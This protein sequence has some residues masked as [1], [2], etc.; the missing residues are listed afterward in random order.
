MYR[1]I[2]PF[3]V[4][5]EPTHFDYI[6]SRQKLRRLED[7]SAFFTPDA[8][9]HVVAY[10]SSSSVSLR[11]IDHFLTHMNEKDLAWDNVQTVHDVH[12]SYRSWLSQWGRRMFDCFR[13][14]ERVYFQYENK[15]HATTP[16]QLNFMVF[17][18][19]HNLIDIITRNMSIVRMNR[20]AGKR[21]QPIQ[22]ICH[23]PMVKVNANERIYAFPV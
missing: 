5:S 7:I 22:T 20:R 16:A 12:Q 1:C 18:I 11:D 3:H 19:S 14:H 8:L 2:G 4:A 6:R 21:K 10:T 9:M 17:A 15:W 13:R 23:M